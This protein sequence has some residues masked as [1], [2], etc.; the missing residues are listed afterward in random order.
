VPPGPRIVVGPVPGP[1]WVRA[2]VEAGG[3]VLVEPGQADAVVWGGAPNDVAGLLA[4]VG[5]AANA[6]WV[7]LPWAGVEFYVEAGVFDHDH[8]WT[9]GK[10]VYAEPVAEHALALALAGLRD[11]P[12]RVRATSWAKQS[13]VSL[14]DGRVTILGGG[15]ITEA[16]LPLLAP[17]RVDV[18]VVRR[19]ALPMPGATRTVCVFDDDGGSPRE[20]VHQTLVGADVVFLALALTPETTG[21]ID[22][23]ALAAMEPHAW[24]VN[25][26]RGQHVVTDDLVAALRDRVIGGAGL[27]VTD[28][29]P[30]PDG[31][32][33]WDLPNCIITPHTANTTEMARPMLTARITENVRRFGAG[34]PLIGLVDADRGY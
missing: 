33:L 20:R 6:R 25:V 21:I 34:E 9:C 16:L 29:E 22:A 13:G 27:D 14:Y 19:S 3:G 32:P 7:A 23:A 17:M 4:L 10:G 15:G 1:D 11:F 8:V 2:A 28:P 18:T 31:H 5:E 30:L 24:L 26:A 12:D